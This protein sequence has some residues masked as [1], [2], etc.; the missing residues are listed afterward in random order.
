MLCEE[1]VNTARDRAAFAAELQAAAPF[2]NSFAESSV[3][4]PFQVI[5]FICPQAK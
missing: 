4:L 1:M 5:R 2:S 3:L